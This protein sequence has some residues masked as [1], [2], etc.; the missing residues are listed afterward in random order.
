MGMRVEKDSLGDVMVPD[1]AFYGSFTVRAMK[2]FQISGIKAH[3]EFILSLARIK[4]CCAIANMK[5]EQLD[6]KKALAISAAADEII[7]SSAVYGTFEELFPLDVFQAGAGTP[8]N[9]NMN[10]VLA[11]IASDK[12]GKKKGTYLV[13]PNNHVNMA[14]SSNDVIPTAVRLACL[15][16]LPRLEHELA[17]LIKEFG[18]KA[19]H[20]KDIVKV[21]M[22]HLEDAVPITFGQVF[23]SFAHSLEEALKKVRASKDSLSNIPI[24]GTAVGTGLNA[25]P[26]F[27]VTVVNELSKETNHKLRPANDSIQLTW[28][29]QDFLELSS[30]LRI[31]AVELNKIS[32]DLR[33][34]N[35]GPNTALAQISLPEVEPGSSIMPGKVNPSIPECM[36]MICF[37]VIGNDTAV[38]HAADA[39]QLELNVMTPVI[40]HNLF[41]SIEI[42]TN[43]IK[44]LND[45]SIR[46]LKVNEERC[47]E[48]L[49][50]NPVIATSLNPYLGYEVVAELVKIALRENKPIR[51]IVQRYNLVQDNLLDK[52]LNAKKLT[53]PLVADTKLADK[54]RASNGYKNFRESIGK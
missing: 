32:N 53:Q 33:L 23:Y 9:M 46:G 26:K 17:S 14:Q 3:K 48:L 15:V 47:Q 6:K 52:L 19:R 11:N 2:N 4:K 50:K 29:M 16:L 51:Q 36:N 25:H 40:A 37:Q 42:L 7:N 49:E 28:S 21:G 31:I 1:D 18:K 54:I 8:F 12:L 5:L 41:T 34:M 30:A 13:H 38:S 39:S 24:G 43:G 35:S 27:K 45:L 44:M 20:Y 10:E 22:T